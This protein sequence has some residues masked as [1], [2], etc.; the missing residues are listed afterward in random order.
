M[1]K[2]I[3]RK[4]HADVSRAIVSRAVSSRVPYTCIH[5]VRS[6]VSLFDFS[7]VITEYC[8]TI[9]LRVDRLPHILERIGTM[10]TNGTCAYCGRT[11][12]VD[13]LTYDVSVYGTIEVWCEDCADAHAVECERC[14]A[15]VSDD[16]VTS[17][18]AW[19]GRGFSE[20]MWCEDCT[21][22]H[23]T[24]CDDCGEY[25][26]DNEVITGFMW[27]GSHVSL[28]PDCYDNYY[29]CEDCG[30]F[31]SSDDAE[32]H[33]HDVYCPNC[34]DNHRGVLESYNHTHGTPFWRCDPAHDFHL[35]SEPCPH[36]TLMYF[37]VELETDDNDDAEALAQDIID[38]IGGDKVCCKRDSSLDCEGVEIV[39]QPMELDAHVSLWERV[40]LIVRKHNGRSHDAGT[41]GLHVHVSRSALRDG[42]VYRM[43]RLLQRFATQFIRFS[44]RSLSS[45]NRWC[46]IESGDELA[47]I[48]DVNARKAAWSD[49]KR[50]CGRYVALNTVPTATVEFRLWRGSLN[51]ETI[52]ASIQMSAALA[53][54]GNSLTDEQVET[55]TWD[56]LVYSALYAV[57]R[58]DRALKRGTYLED[59]ASGRH[60]AYELI[61]YLARRDLL[62]KDFHEDTWPND[63][64]VRSIELR[65]KA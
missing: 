22:D 11:I 4:T 8:D 31:V 26:A 39:S 24:E 63:E 62:P 18:H 54:L 46:A 19:Y 41:C 27:N 60:Y 52:C 15:L 5:F 53:L 49:K 37:G 42:A 6:I 48:A 34:I 43:D 47:K 59:I 65:W 57:D 38:E 2:R 23:A 56:E 30:D 7:R 55:I 32:W 12:D 16:E 58:Y 50:W 61:Q 28:C 40:A 17:V 14:G 35:I 13:E 36:G 45:I 51:L 21:N 44:R 25:W 3:A 29:R 33:N 1:H 9:V 20:Q 64:H 10:R